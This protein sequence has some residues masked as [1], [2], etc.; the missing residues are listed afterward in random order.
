MVV[1]G[2]YGAVWL[3][4][5]AGFLGCLAA[6]SIRHLII[7]KGVGVG[8]DDTKIPGLVVLYAIIASLA[9]SLAAKEV[10]DLAELGASAGLGALAGLFSAMLLA[11]LLITYH[12][13]PGEKPVIKAVRG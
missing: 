6:V 12:T 13:H 9:G 1:G 4:V 5:L 10:S 3:A 7:N 11:M 8:R 2:S